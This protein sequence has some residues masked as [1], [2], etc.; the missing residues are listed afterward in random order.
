MLFLHLDLIHVVTNMNRDSLQRGQTQT[1]H[2][3][4]SRSNCLKS[5][6]NCAWCSHNCFRGVNYELEHR[7]GKYLDDGEETGLVDPESQQLSSDAGDSTWLFAEVNTS[8]LCVESNKIVG[9][10][11]YA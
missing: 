9:L 6:Q 7:G 10:P 4:G 5:F 8:R 1:R 11:G 2:T 3:L